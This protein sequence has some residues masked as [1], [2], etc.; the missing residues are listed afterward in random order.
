MGVRIPIFITWHEVNTQNSN[1][2]RDKPIDPQCELERQC[3]CDKTWVRRR[4]VNFTPG[5]TLC[6]TTLN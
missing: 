2:R 6:N 4:E 1:Y 3:S 5:E